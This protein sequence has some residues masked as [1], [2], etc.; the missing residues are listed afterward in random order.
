MKKMILITA[1]LLSIGQTF[2]H[3]GHGCYKDVSKDIPRYH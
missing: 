1:L 2:A 3:S